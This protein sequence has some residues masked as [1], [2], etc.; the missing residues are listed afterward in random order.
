MTGTSKKRVNISEKT[1]RV[2]LNKIRRC[3]TKN[4]RMLTKT[5]RELSEKLNL[6]ERTIQRAYTKMFQERIAKRDKN[7][8]IIL[9]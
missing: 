1:Y 8:R 4:E 5:T 2:I 9:K 7:N 6:S 3:S